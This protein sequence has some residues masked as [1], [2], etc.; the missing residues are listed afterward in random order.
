MSKEKI[1][2]EQLSFG[3]NKEYPS[4]LEPLRQKEKELGVSSPDLIPLKI[5]LIN[6]YLGKGDLNNAYKHMKNMI[7]LLRL[8]KNDNLRQPHYLEEISD[9]AAVIDQNIPGAGMVNRLGAISFLKI[10]NKKE[11]KSGVLKDI[12]FSLKAELVNL[13]LKKEETENVCGRHY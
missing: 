9:L 13:S 12:A 8:S 10:C 6:F 3:F 1:R 2:H 7:G 5:K 4:L 11:R